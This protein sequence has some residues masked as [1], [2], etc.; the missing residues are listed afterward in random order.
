[1]SD[2][3]RRADVIDAI[4]KMP[5]FKVSYWCKEYLIKREDMIKDIINLPPAADGDKKGKWI[6]V[7]SGSR[8]CHIFYHKCSKCGYTTYYNPNYCCECGSYNPETVIDESA[9]EWAKQLWNGARM[10]GGG[11][12][13]T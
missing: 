7:Y 6:K 4:K 2:L 10:S 9:D 12:D 13:A 5:R 11:E 8:D 3:I 1:M